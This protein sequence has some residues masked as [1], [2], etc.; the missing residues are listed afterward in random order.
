[1]TASPHDTLPKCLFR[2]AQASPDA[3]AMRR[4][5]F[6]IW[7]RI[8][9]RDYASEV[10]RIAAGLLATGIGDAPCLA[11]IGDNEP[12]LFWS[13]LAAQSAGRAMSCQY[14]DLTAEELA[15]NL[16]DCGAKV[17]FAEDQEQ[18]DKLLQIA[19]DLDLRL[20]V[21][22]DERGLDEYDD[23]R[24]LSLTALKE[25]GDR[26]LETDPDCVMRIV[27]AGRSDDLA[28]VIYTSGTTGTPK[29]VMGSHRY[30]L[31]I[32]ER[33]RSVLVPRPGADYV[34]YISPAWAT[35]Q[36]L[37]LALGVSLPLLV[38]FPEEPETVTDDMREIG[39]EFLFFSP[40]QWE[41]VVS[42]TEARMRDAV[43]IVRWVYRVGMGLL[44][45]AHSTPGVL[46]R[47]KR[48]LGHWVIGRPLRDR[49][50]FTHLKTAVNSGSTLSPEVFSFF[51]A[52]GV[53]LHNVYGFTEIGIVTA[54]RDGDPTNCVGRVLESRF[55]T[56]PLQLRTADDE[57]QVRGGA[58]FEGYFGRPE[59]T[60]ERFTADGW[61][62]SGDAGI[63]DE[64]GRLIYLDRLED[65]RKLGDGRTIAPQHIETRF[66]LSPYIRDV[67]VVCEGRNEPAA[68]IDIDTEM[69]GRWCED[70]KI[71][72][73][74]Q[75]DLSQHHA[76]YSLIRTEIQSIN[77][78]L[79]SDSRVGRF[80]NL[81][82]PFDADEGE[83][84]RSKK[85][86]R[87]VIESKYADLIDAVYGPHSAVRASIEVKYQDGRARQLNAMITIASVDGRPL[88]PIAAAD[89]ADSEA[90]HLS[91]RAGGRT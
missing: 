64:E 50:G 23:P 61:I 73:T 46:S 67:I 20:I 66:R 65:I 28:V 40:R 62:K 36:Y 83:L 51:H 11:A 87:G 16:R 15:V 30:L 18:C 82:K 4:K 75:V 69:V 8:T 33:W 45:S 88:E 41:A 22:W 57:V 90:L 19:D 6:G 80:I 54:T 21:Y 55:G 52:L 78:T 43:P 13:E 56:E 58:I 3:I 2:N 44:A 29:G 70:K 89:A 53:S 59:E 63:I 71:S 47:V 35:E 42:S 34:S 25:R 14:P 49:L 72:F 26:L 77:A 32:S 37:G 86:R 17:V 39:P 31:D 74:S 27:E 48:M 12:E 81:L 91:Q 9:W 5:V 60:A 10:R 1:M 85:L 68:L 24:L 38:N 7:H 76:V 79:P 84:T